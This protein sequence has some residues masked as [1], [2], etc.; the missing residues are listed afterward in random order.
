MRSE[1]LMQYSPSDE[2]KTMGLDHVTMS[3][4]EIRLFRRWT[5]VAAGL[6]NNRTTTNL[7]AGLHGQFTH[8]T[9][10][11]HKIKVHTHTGAFFTGTFLRDDAMRTFEPMPSQADEICYKQKSLFFFIF[12]KQSFHSQS[13]WPSL[14]G[15]LLLLVSSLKRCS[16]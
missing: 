5:S 11:Q 2:R 4:N 7:L 12:T 14:L 13:P 10:K 16:C 6:Q 9:T 15:G 3:T 1:L 8:T